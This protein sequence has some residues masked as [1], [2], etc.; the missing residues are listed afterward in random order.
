MAR[1]FVRRYRFSRVVDGFLVPATAEPLIASIIAGSTEFQEREIGGAWLPR[2]VWR[3]AR[4]SPG[5]RPL[6]NCAETR[7]LKQNWIS[8]DLSASAA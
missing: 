2:R 8:S 1:L 3:G 7:L 6:T 4:S 5:R